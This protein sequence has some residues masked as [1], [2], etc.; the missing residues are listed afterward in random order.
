MKLLVDAIHDGGALAAI[1]LIPVTISRHHLSPINIERREIE[2]IVTH[3]QKAAEACAE[4]GF[5]GL[6]PHGAHGFVLNQFFSPVQNTRTDEFGGAIENRMRLALTI[7]NMLRP[8]C[9]TDMLLLYRHTPI[10]QGYDVQESY[11]FAEALIQ[12]GV[13]V[14]D[15]SPSSIDY[16]GDKSVPFKELGVPV[17]AVNEL[18]NVKRALEVLKNDRADLVGIGRGLIAD[19]EWPRKVKESCFHDIVECTGCKKK[20]YGN[21][22]K[23]LPIECAKWNS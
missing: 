16:P 22:E 10:G 4:A 15:M 8:I 2:E 6:E 13:D 1:Q 3:Y 23:G 14:L 9:G 19:P 11:L 7:I 17:I 5:D 18:H 12:A 21:L 20:C